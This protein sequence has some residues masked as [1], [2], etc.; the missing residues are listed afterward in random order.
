MKILFLTL[1]LPDPPTVGA[2]WRDFELY[3][4]MAA[5]HDVQVVALTESTA[6]DAPREDRLGR[7]HPLEVSS[8]LGMHLLA[9]LPG[10]LAQRWPLATLPFVDA[11]AL[12]A[13][14]DLVHDWKPDVLQVE[15]SFLAPYIQAAEG[16]PAVRTVLSLHNIG[17]IQYDRMRCS[18][19]GLR[20][21]VAAALKAWTMRGWE[22]DICARFNR[23]VV[24]SETDREWLLERNPGLEI[25]VVVNGVDLGQSQLPPASGHELLFVGNLAYGPNIDAV[26]YFCEAIFPIIR[27]QLPEARFTAAG[28]NPPA[29]L[30]ELDQ[31][32][33]VAIVGSAPE[34]RAYYAR[35]AVCVVPLRAGGGTRLKILEAMAL[36]RPVVSTSIGCEGLDGRD[37][38]H[39][40]VADDP[41]EF[42]RAVV[43][44]CLDRSK[45]LRLT[46]RARQ[47]C[48]TRYGWDTAADHLEGTYSGEF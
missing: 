41:A 10:H 11:G 35:S 40:L 32:P 39:L 20:E 25:N 27:R 6:P 48:D 16:L 30:L 7:V 12:R 36:G 33:G 23:V 14:H 13:L 29:S 15:H 26:R 17:E 38:E 19:V 43:T 8:E 21:R 4:R 44:L 42:A 24:V 34:L 3:R 5:R 28:F 45:A 9:R 37:G 46:T 2:Q 1:G 18:A 47:L 22:T 31:L